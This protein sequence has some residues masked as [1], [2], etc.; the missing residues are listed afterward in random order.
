[1]FGPAERWLVDGGPAT[2][3][4]IASVTRSFCPRP[5]LCWLISGR[6]GVPWSHLCA[7]DRAT[8]GQHYAAFA[9]IGTTRPG[10]AR[11]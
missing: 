2:V 10:P 9:R 7:G 8:P 11:P 4:V 6:D 5:R 3:G 1:M